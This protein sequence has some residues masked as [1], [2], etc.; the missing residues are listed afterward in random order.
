MALQMKGE[1]ESCAE[2]TPK[3]IASREWRLRPAGGTN[4][5]KLPLTLDDKTGMNSSHIYTEWS[6]LFAHELDMPQCSRSMGK[7]NGPRSA[8][9][10]A[11]KGES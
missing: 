9:H 5:E 10:T 2:R 3:V 8:V 6:E 1:L 4:I 11:A 7:T